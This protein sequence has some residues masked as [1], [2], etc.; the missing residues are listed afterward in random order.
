MPYR[1]GGRGHPR[2]ELTGDGGRPR[3]RRN[4]RRDPADRVGCGRGRPGDHVHLGTTAA[5]KGVLLTQALYVHRET[6]AR[7]ARLSARQSWFVV[8]PLFHATRSTTASPR[9]SRS[10]RRRRWRRGSSPRLARAQAAGLGVTHATRSPRRARMIL[11][12]GT[13]R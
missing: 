13:R 9:R 2:P 11:S 8:L 10:A 4:R 12:P 1:G 3:R 5:P 7:A 6:M